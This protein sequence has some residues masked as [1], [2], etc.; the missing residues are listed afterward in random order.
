MRNL[1]KLIFQRVVM[2]SVGIL[3]QLV[4][5]VLFMDWL[6]A[7][8]RWFQLLMLGLRGFFV[9]YLVSSRTNPAYKIAWLILILAF[10]VAGVS[11][12]LFLGG[13][14]LSRREKRRMSGLRVMVESNLRQSPEVQKQ[15]QLLH[16]AAARQ[17]HY[18]QTA[19]GSPVWD[20][21]RT[22][23]FSCGEDCFPRMLEELQKAKSYIFLEYFIVEEGKMW[24]Q[25]LDILQ[26]KAA[27]GVD[28]RLIYDDFG[29]ITR[30]PAKYP[31]QMK[32]LGIMA[33]AFNPFVPVVSGRLNNR[34]HRK[35]MIIDG[36]VGFTGGINLADEYIN[37]THPFGY[38]KDSGLLLE[39]PGVWSMTVQFLSMWNAIHGT[40]EELQSYDPHAEPLPASGFVQP[41][42]D[43]PL[44]HEEVGETVLL[45]LI[46]S[47][48]KSIR[49]MTPYLV[50]DDKM[51]TALCNAAK[52]GLD[53]TVITPGI[54][55]KWYVY[56]VTRHNYRALTAAGVR[57]YEFTPG[58][59]HSKVF[60]VDG[61]TALVGTVNLDFRSL[62]LHFENAV[63]L[64][65]AD[66]LASIEADFLKTIPLC[67]QVT[68][69]D[70]LSVPLHVRIFRSVLH[71]LA[72]LM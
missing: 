59:L 38:W 32:D 68:Y 22:E 54:A 2:V 6:A 62:Y 58:F 35:L 34:D 11:I 24:G 50:L 63:W 16:P 27:S 56:S 46:N 41:F 17:S 71:L 4:V 53:V 51:T 26:K 66:C 57:V 30:L 48:K 23:Y 3:L 20:G 5:V 64:H 18:L 10:P 60:C 25:I 55:D 67:R 47:A 42:G 36:R 52:M 29:C 33:R 49:I 8:Q 19:A 61:G 44:D 43:S 31:R 65:D 39:G 7:Y 9:V 40:S 37:Q 21:T 14:K 28:V 15:L 69:H 45:N 1:G 12:Y 72:P 70:A 13:N